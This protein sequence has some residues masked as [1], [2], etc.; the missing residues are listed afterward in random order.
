MMPKTQKQYEM[1]GTK[2]KNAVWWLTPTFLIVLNLL[3]GLVAFMQSGRSYVV[4]FGSRKW[5]DLSY[6]LICGVFLLVLAAGVW[7]GRN[8][9]KARFRNG[10]CIP[11]MLN[12]KRMGTAFFVVTGICIMAYL[13]WFTNFARMYGIRSF[14][15]AFNTSALSSNMYLFHAE[16]GSISGVTTFTEFGVISAVLGALLLN[17]DDVPSLT[18]RRIKELLVLVLILS[19]FRATLFSER[20][21]IIELVVPFAIAWFGVSC[22]PLTAL[23]RWIPLLAV[24]ILVLFFGLLEYSRSWLTH[25]VNYYDSFWDFIL[26]RVFGYYTNAANVEAMYIHNGVTS[27]LPYYSIQW[28][29]QMPGMGD[30]YS[31]IADPDV[32]ALYNHLLRTLVNPELNNPGGVLTFY[33]DFSWFGLLFEFVFGY[34]LGRF[35]EGYRAGSPLHLIM[36]SVFFLTMIELPRYFYLGVNR[37]FIVVVCVI[38]VMFVCGGEAG[39]NSFHSVKE[40]HRCVESA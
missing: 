14:A 26:M 16:N 8:G 9:L 40:R 15:Y 20:L 24:A 5:I 34:L 32:G 31:S 38:V 36:Y 39:K 21:A 7:F 1:R 28:L 4:E 2:R 13:I 17:F 30:F 25:Y 3:I 22:K 12:R 35:Y 37:G 33:K 29:W 19:Y 11:R 6:L 27:W 18:K 23:E 10:R